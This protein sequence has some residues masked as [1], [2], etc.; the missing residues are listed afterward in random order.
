MNA[1]SLDHSATG[2]HGAKAGIPNAVN[3]AELNSVEAASSW[4]ERFYEA[5]RT[6]GLEQFKRLRDQGP[7]AFSDSLDFGGFCVP[8][9][10]NQGER[11][12]AMAL[13]YN[14][15]SELFQRPD[16]FS[17]AFYK[18]QL[19]PSSP[20]NAEGLA[21][22]Q[23]RR[24]VIQAFNPKSIRVW[25][26]LARKEAANLV[27]ELAVAGGGDLV[28]QFCRR[29]PGAV[30]S[31]F[32]DAPSADAERLSAWAIR[33]MFAY[34][35]QGRQAVKLV[36]DYMDGLI[37]DRRSLPLE[38]LRQRRDLVSLLISVNVDG[39]TL[40]DEEINTSLHNALI[41]GIDTTAKGL[42][43][44]LYFLLTE[45]GVRDTVRAGPRELS[46]A[47][48]ESIRLGSPNV[49]GGARATLVDTTLD[50]VPVPKGAWVMVNLPMANRDAGRWD[51]AET[52]D[53]ER[54]MIPHL[55]WGSGPHVCMGMNLAR[56]II[57]VGVA[58]LLEKHPNVRLN[59]EHS[60][61]Q[62]TGIGTISPQALH[63]VF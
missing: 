20:F 63:V 10:W 39:R 55:G 48:E 1:K 19:G 15:V 41:G 56:L 8:N 44:T 45:P 22:L 31:R 51:H 47:I 7:V 61:P 49:F 6:D 21:H 23:F 46:L 40:T 12:Y 29:L 17:K 28:P 30:Y 37:A 59:E 26:E 11:R 43:S 62:L 53:L 52:F 38:E 58:V 14:A 9:L 33:Q 57:S 24:M 3:G 16:V 32:I 4:F 42:A 25:D 36:T 60:R 5:E 18:A 34:D 50:G 13:S 35:E 2:R 54:P 27:D